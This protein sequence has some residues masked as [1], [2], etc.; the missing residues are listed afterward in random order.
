MNFNSIKVSSL[1][2]YLNSIFKDEAW[3]DFETETILD[4]FG[5]QVNELLREKVNLCKVLY[6][7]PGL[8]FEDIMF[9]L[10]SVEVFNDEIADFT[11]V[12]EVNSLEVALAITEMSKVLG[13]KLESLPHFSE[14][15]RSIINLVLNDEGYSEAV[16]PFDV[17]GGLTL[18]EGQTKEDTLKKKRAIEE[19][20]RGMYN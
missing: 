12:P 18:T 19:Y 3:W 8:F 5:F 20:I 15:I 16:S 4:E 6:N 10:H 14:G 13:V 11:F 7:R 1:Y 2:S 9:F 17:V